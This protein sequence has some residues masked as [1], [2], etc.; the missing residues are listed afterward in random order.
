MLLNIFL[1]LG[2]VGLV[3]Y[4][5]T[6]EFIKDNTK[7]DLKIEELNAK[8]EELKRQHRNTIKQLLR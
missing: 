4:C 7:K 3:S 1:W 8:L 2:S 5:I 6:G